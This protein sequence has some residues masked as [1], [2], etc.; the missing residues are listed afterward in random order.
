MQNDQSLLVGI[1][2]QDAHVEER[3]G[4]L[5]KM[6]AKRTFQQQNTTCS[7]K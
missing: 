6:A 2:K 5:S 1:F 4:G 7:F 3:K